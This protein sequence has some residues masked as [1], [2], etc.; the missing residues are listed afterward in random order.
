MT[1]GATTFGL[2]KSEFSKKLSNIIKN[3]RANSKLIGEPKEFILRCCKL[4]ERWSKL[5]NDPETVIYLRYND[6]SGGRR[7][8]MI[9][10][11]RGNTKQPIP[12]NQILDALYPAKKIS[13]TATPEEKH[14]NAVKAAM[15]YAVKHQL[16]AFR[17][18]SGPANICYLTGL[19]L[20][21]YSKTDVD[22]IGM[23]FSEIADRFIASQNLRYTD[24][25]LK[26]PPTAKVFTDT[27]LWV[28]W[29]DFHEEN[30]KFALVCSSANR[31]KGADGYSVDLE[32]IGSFQS[33]DP[34]DL[35]L[36]F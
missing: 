15:R 9:Y 3:F 8:K 6:T 24:I 1:L 5:A 33:E 31:S 29:I 35:A 25:T 14:F 11:E 13:T 4:T 16:Q 34:E 20:R 21:P 2:N 18:A 19:Q 27:L 22:H 26:G 17:D 36:D 10:L 30:A 32:L 28:K 23:P 12:K 7:V